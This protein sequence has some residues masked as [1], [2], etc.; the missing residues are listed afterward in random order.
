MGHVI[1]LK[2]HLP[3]PAASREIISSV[4]ATQGYC[5]IGGRKTGYE[6]SSGGLKLGTPV[7]ELGIEGIVV[8]SQEAQEVA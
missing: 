2:E 8:L 6:F 3:R 7:W 5:A 1:G 4:T